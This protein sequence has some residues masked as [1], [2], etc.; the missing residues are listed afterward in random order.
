MEGIVFK[1]NK[2]FSDVKLF[3]RRYEQPDCSNCAYRHRN[4]GGG[5]GVLAKEKV[6]SDEGATQ[7]R[8]PEPRWA[9]C[10]SGAVGQLL[11]EGRE[12]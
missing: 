3:R 5:D 1:L 2:T 6:R 10:R 4:C 12:S 7:D 11:K 9:R 8:Q